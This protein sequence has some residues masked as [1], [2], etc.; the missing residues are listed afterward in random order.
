MS[1]RTDVMHT[2]LVPPELK[3]Q[4]DKISLEVFPNVDEHGVDKEG[5]EWASSEILVLAWDDDEWGGH[6]GIL[7]RTI[8]VGGTEVTVG[9]VGGVMTRPDMRG[10][11]L[12]KAALRH[13]G[14]VICNEMGADAG[15]LY[16]LPTMQGYYGAAGW[17]E[18][19]RQIT[20][21]QS[22][23]AH[24]LDTRSHQ[25]DSAMF[26]P[27]NGFVFPHGPIDVQGKLW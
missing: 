1:I 8:E 11:G 12:G 20:Y 25:T 4:I 19:Q 13:A 14:D 2:H 21:H 3:E 17:Y 15:M 22:D 5:I 24:V 23:G 9:G 7:R 10:R 6:V 26:L 16:C 18:L 27:C